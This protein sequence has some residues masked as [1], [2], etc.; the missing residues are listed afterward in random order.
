MEQSE[1]KGPVLDVG[2]IELQEDCHLLA[3]Q[4][5]HEDIDLFV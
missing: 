5:V 4:L 3:V 2:V 1:A